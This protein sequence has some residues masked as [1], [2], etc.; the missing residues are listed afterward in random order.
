[1]CKSLRLAGTSHQKIFFFLS[2]NSL[3][4]E[5]L[6]NWELNGG[7]SQA[8]KSVHEMDFLFL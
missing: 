6:P 2:L 8:G 3:G 1:M 4:A 5:D 7:K